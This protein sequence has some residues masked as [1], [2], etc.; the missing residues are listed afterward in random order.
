MNLN[1]YCLC[2]VIMVLCD[3]RG[4][5]TSVIRISYF[6]ET[7]CVLNSFINGKCSET[8]EWD[9]N[10]TERLCMVIKNAGLNSSLDPEIQSITHVKSLLFCSCIAAYRSRGLFWMTKIRDMLL[11]SYYWWETEAQCT[12]WFDCCRGNCL[13]PRQELNPA[14]QSLL[15]A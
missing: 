10:K 8:C 15:M 3:S 1:L 6:N 4:V 13:W 7:L 5:A 2:S 11:P 9:L 14:R 12:L